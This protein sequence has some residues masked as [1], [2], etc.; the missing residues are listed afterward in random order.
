MAWYLNKE[1]GIKWEVTDEELIKRLSQDVNYE[2]VEEKKENKSSSTKP[3]T[4]N[5]K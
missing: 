5:K 4:T 3:K 2:I 1:T